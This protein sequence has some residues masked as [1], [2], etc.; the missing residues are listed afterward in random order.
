MCVSNTSGAARGSD[1][2]APVLITGNI[3]APFTVDV[4]M[5]IIKQKDHAGVAVRIG[6]AGDGYELTR[7]KSGNVKLH[8]QFN[9]N[10]GTGTPPAYA[11]LGA[12]SESGS[13]DYVVDDVV[14]MACEIR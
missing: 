3:V 2:I 10:E 1:L 6:Y 5:N 8:H 4:S 12:W 7:A 14:V 13:N 9:G 11:Y